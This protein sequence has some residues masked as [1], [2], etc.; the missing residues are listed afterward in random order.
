MM[1]RAALVSCVVVRVAAAEDAEDVR[2][3]AVE[4]AIASEAIATADPAAAGVASIRASANVIEML[5]RKFGYRAEIGATGELRAAAGSLPRSGAA[6]SVHAGL[7]DEP[8]VDGGP[9]IGVLAIDIA[10][11]RELDALPR[12][13]DPR[14]LLR[15]PYDRKQWRLD[16]TF[17]RV[18]LPRSAW[19]MSMVDAQF[20][21][22]NDVQRAGEL[23]YAR[24]T[25]RIAI[26]AVT[27]CR[28]P[29]ADPLCVRIMHF[30]VGGPSGDNVMASASLMLA[31]VEGVPVSDAVRLDAGLG[32]V[33]GTYHFEPDPGPGDCTMTGACAV[34]KVPGYQ[35]GVRA[36]APRS[37]KV[38]LVRR[39][40][41]TMTNELAIEDR[42]A[43]T[44]SW[45]HRRFALAAYA[46]TAYT[47]WWGPLDRRLVRLGSGVTGGADLTM[48]RAFGH[49]KI[50]SAIAAGRGWYGTPDGDAPR[51][52]LAAQGTLA[53]RHEWRKRSR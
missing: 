21:F 4:S 2:E 9:T 10:F 1:K 28:A 15:L 24:E 14:D 27:D 20:T 7:G 33:W 44:T 13:R 37:E 31:L 23:V 19:R 49:W 5:G 36:P 26:D 51:A 46:Y 17:V 38:E 29:D 16:T 43:A 50:E 39:S 45:A 53:L 3:V 40:Y 8:L 6:F 11:G 25:A 42:L 34:L 32:L 48:S 22:T 12:L 52:G 35:L 47:R 18:R 41:E 30:G